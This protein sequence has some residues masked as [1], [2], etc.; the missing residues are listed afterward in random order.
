MEIPDLNPEIDHSKKNPA[1]RVLRNVSLNE[2]AFEVMVSGEKTTE[3]REDKAHWQS[4]L[5]QKRKKGSLKD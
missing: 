4:R 5:L 1:V 2:P 3:Y